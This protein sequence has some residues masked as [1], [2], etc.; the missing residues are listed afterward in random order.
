[1]KVIVYNGLGT[2]NKVLETCS[3]NEVIGVVKSMLKLANTVP[4]IQELR[5]VFD[6]GVVTT[7]GYG[8]SDVGSG[9]GPN[10][11]GPRPRPE[12]KFRGVARGCDAE[13]C[14]ARVADKKKGYYT[15]ELAD[16]CEPD[17]EV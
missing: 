10:S 15:D 4:Q 14:G 8:A 11:T 3:E 7:S 9:Y 13:S 12:I 6:S 2:P 16:C 5:C 1:M 17:F